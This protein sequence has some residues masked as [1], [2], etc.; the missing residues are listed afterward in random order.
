MENALTY[1]VISAVSYPFLA[2]YNSCAALF[3]AMGNSRISMQ[4]SVVMNV[5]NIIGDYLLVFV[6]PMG[7]AGA[8]LATLVSRIVACVILNIRLRNRSLDICIGNGPL[9]WNGDMIRRILHIGIPGGV[10]NSIFQLGRVLVVSIIATFGTV[11][12][13]ANAVANNLATIAYLPG[14]ALGL[15]LITIAGQC[16]G[17]GEYRQARDYTRKLLILNYILAGVICVFMFA[18]Q[19][20]LVSIY[21]LSEES[22]QIAKEMIAAHCF[23]MAV[24]PLAFTL[25]YTLRASFDARFT[26]IISIFSMWVFRIGFAYL[27]VL[28]FGF[29]VLGI[30]YGMFIDWIF[31]AAVFVWR[32]KSYEKRLPKMGKLA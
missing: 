28:L 22:G 1:L 27:F 17:A 2:V 3:R 18:G 26:M 12:I 25:P 9:S 32:F 16:V 23:A 21:G 15:G 8:A 5:L 24:W 6:F 20:V 14:N 7:V 31:R 19:G 30:W 13:A 11:Q 4:A 29:G 10:E